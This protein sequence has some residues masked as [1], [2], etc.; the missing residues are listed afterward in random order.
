MTPPAM[1]AAA[2]PAPARWFEDFRLGQQF[3]GGSRRITAED[4]AQFT[5]ISGDRHPLHTDP[6]YAAA[7][8]FRDRLAH[9]PL[10]LALFFGWYHELGLAAD[11][12]IALLDTNWRY[13]AP[14]HVGDTL[15]FEMTITRVRLAG[16]GDRG[17]VGRHVRM[18][19][20]DAVVAQEGTTSVLV[21]ARGDGRVPAQELFTRAWAQA[22][23][24]RLRAHAGFRAATATWDGT[25]GLAAGRDE[26]QLR[27]YRGEVI[28]AGERSVNGATF[29]VVAD[30]LVWTR[31]VTS[32]SNDFMREAMQGAF[33]VRGAAY[34]YLRLAKALAFVV[35]CAR[36]L[37]QEAPQR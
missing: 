26:V 14:V 29:T 4:L 32:S 15:R 27:V 7:Q 5:D 13:T 37:L 16:T 23:A 17:I 24:Q 2:G 11:T 21:R 31:L 12:V 35:D 22:L 8:G 18:L 3:A 1:P 10:G 36:A 6:A 9:G 20:Q 28:E 19:T 33:A 25:I 30:E 34:E